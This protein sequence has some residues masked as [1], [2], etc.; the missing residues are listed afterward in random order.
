MYKSLEGK[1]TQVFDIEGREKAIAIIDR[2]IKAYD[3]KFGKKGE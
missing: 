1:Q 2:Y 3:E